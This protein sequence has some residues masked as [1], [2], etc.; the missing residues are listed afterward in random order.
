MAGVS[1]GIRVLISVAALLLGTT[2]ADQPAAGPSTVTIP[3]GE[4]ASI[5]PQAP[6]RVVDCAAVRAASEWVRACD[7]ES[8]GLQADAYDPD[9]DRM[10]VPVTLTTGA[11]TMTVQYRVVLEAPPAPSAIPPSERMIAAGA[12]LR[13]P[14]SDFSISCVTCAE[15]GGTRVLAI[16]PAEAG[17]AWTT[18]THVVF[19]AANDFQGAADVH[20]AVSDDFGAVAQTGVPVFVYRGDESTGLTALDVYV[21]V[22]EAGGASIDLNALVAAREDSSV[23]IVGCGPSVHGA[24]VCDAMGTAAYRGSMAPDQFSFHVVAGGEQAWGSVTLVPP[25][26]PSGPVPSSPTPGDEP[27]P[28]AII[29]PQPPVADAT[30]GGGMLLPFI[31]LLNRVGAN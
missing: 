10:V 9:A 16:D 4:A 22:D 29:P 18:A 5:E 20:I 13:V 3:Y 25:G 1:R 15:G 26:Q 7:S 6:W 14:L 8:I 17:D 27:V 2:I 19:R 31:A 12:L 28:M 11:R 21:P 30:A 23:H 24:A